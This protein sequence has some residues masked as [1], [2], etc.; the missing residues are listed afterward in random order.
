M[1]NQSFRQRVSVATSFAAVLGGIAMAGFVPASRSQEAKTEG[2]LEEITV[3]GSR[4]LRRDL[5]SNS[6]LVTVDSD[7]LER[8]T[9]LNVESYLNQM[10]N[11]NPAAAPT[12][13]FGPGSNS[14]VQISAVNSVGIA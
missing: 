11:F 4:I 2:A 9:G 6:P 10:P 3:T 13:Q 8:Q 12:I 7:A 14:D 5:E 1:K